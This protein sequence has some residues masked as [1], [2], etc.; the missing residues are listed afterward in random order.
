MR[1]RWVPTCGCDA[2]ESIDVLYRLLAHRGEKPGGATG[3][4]LLCRSLARIGIAFESVLLCETSN[5]CVSVRLPF[6]CRGHAAPS[7]RRPLLAAI[8]MSTDCFLLRMLLRS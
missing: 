3:A 5:I 2:R 7:C 4:M 8:P 1:V 6:C